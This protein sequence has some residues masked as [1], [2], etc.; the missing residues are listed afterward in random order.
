MQPTYTP[1]VNSVLVK[2]SH[3]WTFDDVFSFKMHTKLGLLRIHKQWGKILRDAAAAAA[4]AV[5]SEC[6]SK[7]KYIGITKIFM[8]FGMTVRSARTK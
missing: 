3:L 8:V 6:A 4:N 7:A 2:F 5:F 1:P